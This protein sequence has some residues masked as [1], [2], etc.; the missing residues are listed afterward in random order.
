MKLDQITQAKKE[1]SCKLLVSQVKS[2]NVDIVS[3][4]VLQN[5]YMQVNK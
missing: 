1:E 2:E 3:V 5:R 4:Q